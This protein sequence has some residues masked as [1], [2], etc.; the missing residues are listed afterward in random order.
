MNRELVRLEEQLLYWTC[1]DIRFEK[2]KSPRTA[3]QNTVED[4]MSLLVA[5]LFAVRPALPINYYAK[6]SKHI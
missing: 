2:P 5:R 4:E 6:T 3:F 1:P